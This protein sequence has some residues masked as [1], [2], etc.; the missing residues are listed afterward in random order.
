MRFEQIARKKKENEEK[1]NRSLNEAETVPSMESGLARPD[2][3]AAP[4]TSTTL[5]L[6]VKVLSTPIRKKMKSFQQM[7]SSKIREQTARMPGSPTTPSPRPG[8]SKTSSGQGYPPLGAKPKVSQLISKYKGSN[9]TG[10][11]KF[12]KPI[13]RTK[14]INVSNITKPTYRTLYAR[15]A[16]PTH[17]CSQHR[18]VNPCGKSAKMNEDIK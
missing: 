18:A 5:G 2:P 7:S 3:E 8:T 4:T 17:S 11:P 13:E 15:V 1:K 16:S 6:R 10:Q 12:P 14:H 9:V